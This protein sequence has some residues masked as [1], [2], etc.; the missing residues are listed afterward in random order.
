MVGVAVVIA[1]M[2]LGTGWIALR[3]VLQTE[4]AEVFR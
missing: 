4:P 1:V 2:V 3:K